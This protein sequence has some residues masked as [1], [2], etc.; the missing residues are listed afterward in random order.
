VTF[1][2]L[3]SGIGGFDLGLERAGL[4]CAWQVE[5]DP[6][7]GRLLADKW[8]TVE[9]HDDVRTVGADLATVDLVCGGF[10]CQDLSVA[11]RREGLAGERSG[12]WFEFHRILERTRPRWVIVEN[13]PGLLSSHGGSDFAVLVRGLVQLGY[14]VCWRV[15]DAQYFGVAQRRRR[16]FVVGCLGTGAAAQVLL[17]SA[18]VSGHP[19]PRR[20]PRE[21]PAR[22]LAGGSDGS[23]GYRNDADTADNLVAHT[24]SPARGTGDGHGNAWNSTY[25]AGVSAN[26]R[27]EV[28]ERQVHGSLNGSKSGKQFDGVLAFGWNKSQSQ[29]MRVGELPDAL[30]ASST[31]NPAIVSGPI[32]SN[33]R[34]NSNPGTEAAEIEARGAVRR[35]T[36]RECERLQGFPD[37]WTAGFTDSVRY[38]MLGNAVAVP[39]SAWLGERISDRAGKDQP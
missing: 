29:T 7:C 34:N 12:L 13:V 28:R 11:G 14:G 27:G 32:R 18:C 31:S 21:R 26:Q 25:V 6:H 33:P 1:G 16:V 17:E 15:L 22:P 10:P 19:A 23:G 3:F 5:R 24:V 37:D 8:P 35:L 36:P 2:S 30:Q 39:V 4:S 38:H 9:R 20:A